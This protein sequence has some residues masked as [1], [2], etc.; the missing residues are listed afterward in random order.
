MADAEGTGAIH[1]ADGS[2]PGYSEPPRLVMEGYT[3]I[4]E[5]LRESFEAEYAW[6]DTV[7]LQAGVGGLAAA[8]AER[9]RASWADQPRIVVVEP[10]AAPCLKESV[11][12][13]RIVTVNGPVSVMGRLD[14]KTPSMLAFD[15]LREAADAFVTVSETEAAEASDLMA[16]RGCRRPSGAAGVAAWKRLGGERPLVV[17]SEGP[18]DA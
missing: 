5:E 3:I 9:I 17:L 14:C 15:L 7:Y 2:W 16:P 18:N 13:G 12:A 4:A 6:P 10:E 8:I 11:A 1:L